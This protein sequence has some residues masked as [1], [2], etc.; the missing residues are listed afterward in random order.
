M[1]ILDV[2]KSIAKEFPEDKIEF[3]PSEQ[4]ISIK[5]EWD[6]IDVES[7]MRYA[8]IVR[9]SGFVV[10]FKGTVSVFVPEG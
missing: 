4:Y 7:L 10:H 1:E 2:V 9:G 6:L 3:R 5:P 8:E